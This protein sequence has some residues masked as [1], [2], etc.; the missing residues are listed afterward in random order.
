MSNTVTDMPETSGFHNG[1]HPYPPE[2]DTAQYDNNCG[3][4][5]AA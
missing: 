4:G 2:R 3:G 5:C 1:L